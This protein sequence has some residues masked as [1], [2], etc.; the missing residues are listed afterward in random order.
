MKARNGFHQDR[1][2]EKFHFRTTGATGVQKPAYS[3]S[4]VRAVADS[5]SRSRSS[6]EGT[7]ADAKTAVR[8]DRNFGNGAHQHS[9]GFFRVRELDRPFE[10]APKNHARIHK[11]QEPQCLHSLTCDSCKTKPSRGKGTNLAPEGRD[12]NSVYA[13]CNRTNEHAHG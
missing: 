3:S 9:I 11:C 6:S 10:T 7:W 8:G 5:G 4:G 1:A 12:N 2:S 13:T